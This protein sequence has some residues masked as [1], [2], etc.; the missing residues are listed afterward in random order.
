M[1][2][3]RPDDALARFMRLAGVPDT[4]IDA[5]LDFFG[6][7]AAAIMDLLPHG[8]SHRLPSQGHVA[9]AR[10]L[11]AVLSDFFDPAHQ[12]STPAGHS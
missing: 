4:D 11:A 9:D 3:G 12:R 6:P 7:A 10:R 2:E 1:A 8:E 5:G